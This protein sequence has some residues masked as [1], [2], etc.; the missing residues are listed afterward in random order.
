MSL[1]TEQT[2]ALL[3]ALAVIHR[4]QASGV[5]VLDGERMQ[6]RNANFVA[7]TS[8]HRERLR[9]ARRTLEQHV[10]DAFSRTNCAP[11]FEPRANIVG[12]VEVAVAQVALRIARLVP[13]RSELECRAV[14]E[15]PG[16]LTAVGEMLFQAALL[17][18]EQAALYVG[19]VSKSELVQSA[20]ALAPQT[21]SELRKT[22]NRF[23]QLGAYEHAH[24][25]GATELAIALRA[26]RLSDSARE[27]KGWRRALGNAHPDKLGPHATRAELAASDEI[28]ARFGETRSM[29]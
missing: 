7:A 15:S 27:N 25:R 10:A 21:L 4:S 26:A 1:N 18:V 20:S 6:V 9:Y 5:F 23:A 28:F 14:L 22:M 3:R 16:A 13:A 24:A 2:L 11:V 17:P 12:S 19:R 29:H 8:V